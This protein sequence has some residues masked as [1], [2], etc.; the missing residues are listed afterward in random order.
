MPVLSVAAQAKPG[1]ARD[2][3]KPAMPRAPPAIRIDAGPSP[4]RIDAAPSPIRIEGAIAAQQRWSLRARRA[5]S[6]KDAGSLDEKDPH[7]GSEVPR[8]ALLPPRL[9]KV[10]D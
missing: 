9:S 4:M 5:E 8:L 1:T 3:A 10:P 7:R 2:S 6:L